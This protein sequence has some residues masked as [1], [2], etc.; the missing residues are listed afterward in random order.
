MMTLAARL[1]VTAALVSALAAALPAEAQSTW[2]ASTLTGDRVT[3]APGDG[4]GWGVAA[5]GVA[6]GSTRYYIWVTAIATPTAAHIHEGVAGS[7]GGVAIDLSASFNEIAPGTW[8]A[9]GEVTGG[10][11]AALLSNPGAFYV[12]VHNGDHPAGAIRGQVLGDGAARQSLAGTLRGYRQVGSSGDPDGDG[13]G[14]V[15]FA[16]GSAHFYLSAGNVAAPTAA[17]IHM[18]TATEAGGIVVDTEAAFSDEVSTTTVAVDDDTA[19]MILASPDDFYFNVHNAEFPAGAIRGQLRPTETVAFFPV[20]SRAVGQAG[21]K[22]TTGLRLI[23]LAD[24]T[25]TAFADWFPSSGSAAS[26]PAA[27]EPVT[28]HAGEL[29]VI[30]DAVSTL[31]AAN[32]N[33]AVKIASSEPFR[34]AARIFNDQR[35]NPEIGGTFGQAAPAYDEDDILTSGVLLLGSNRPAADGEGF[36]TNVGYFNP[37]PESVTA[38]IDVRDTAGGVLGA[39]SLTIPAFS[40]RIRNIFDLVPSVPQGDRR[41]ED[42]LVTFSASRPLLMYLSAVDNVTSDAIFV[43]AEP[44]PAIG[45]TTANTPPNGTIVSPPGD[46][47]IQEGETVSFEGD[48]TDPDGDEMTYLW[49]FGDGMSSTSLSPGD[50]TYSDSGTYTV[51]FTVTDARGAVDPTPATRTITVDGGGGELATFTSVQS[52]VFNASCAFSGCHAGSSPSQGLDLSSGAAY[53][54]IV[55]VP[56]AQQPSLD[57]IEPNDP[58]SS[59]LY[60]K[61]TGDASISGGR[62]PRGAQPLSQELLD[63]VRDWI[64]RGAPND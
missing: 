50:H 12:N 37:W 10:S 64:E 54:E 39:D 31:F 36:R 56:S 30:D 28:L 19:A 29:A 63:L 49:D 26:G 38:E 21:S 52:R 9:T 61:L 60:L 33:G 43:M 58:D 62:M 34:S 11:T 2:F 16:G 22:W 3:G 7:N 4:D 25:V 17:H 41:Q 18:G 13:F 55:N 14:V 59:Y 48:A 46:V 23:G 5:V 20:I 53:N 47:S 1:I 51:T 8:V 6:G 57:R 32:G 44:A 40:N 35:D 27:T 24:E 45:T 42:V 15:T